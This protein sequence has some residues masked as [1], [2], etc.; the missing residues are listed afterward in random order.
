MLESP[1]ESLNM[2]ET[3]KTEKDPNQ[4]SRNENFNP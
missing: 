1:E 4:T 2:I 3:W